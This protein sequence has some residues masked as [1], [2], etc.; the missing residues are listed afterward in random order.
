VPVPDS[1]G[2][3]Q[4]QCRQC[5]RPYG[6]RKRASTSAPNASQAL[7]WRTGRGQGNRRLRKTNQPA[8]LCRV[9]GGQPTDTSASASA[10]THRESRSAGK[11][12][13]RRQSDCC[14]FH[15]LFSDHFRPTKN[16]PTRLE[17]PDP[18]SPSRHKACRNGREGRCAKAAPGTVPPSLAHRPE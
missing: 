7:A 17:V 1:A 15:G 11:R 10:A 16:D 2:A 13:H 4:C 8:A 18:T 14:E 12:D 5:Q 3:R 6:Q 9:S